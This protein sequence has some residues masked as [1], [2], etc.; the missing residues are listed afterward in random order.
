MRPE[1]ERTARRRCGHSQKQYS[2]VLCLWRSQQKKLRP[3]EFVRLRGS[4]EWTRRTLTTKYGTRPWMVMPPQKLPIPLPSHPPPALWLPRFT[5]LRNAKKNTPKRAHVTLDQVKCVLA[6]SL[7]R[8]LCPKVAAPP[9]SRAGGRGSRLARA[10]G[11][12]AGPA[13]CCSP[14]CSTTAQVALGRTVKRTARKRREHRRERRVKG[15]QRGVTR[16]RKGNRKA[17]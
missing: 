8:S 16:Q 5:C 13:T 9:S 6:R 3:N 7:A 1:I 17:S 12:A 15:T 2:A 4:L 11:F 14:A 10:L